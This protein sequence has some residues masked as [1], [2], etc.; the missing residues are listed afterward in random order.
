[1]PIYGD[2]MSLLQSPVDWRLEGTS[3]WV[4]MLTGKDR[5]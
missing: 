2:G 4:N 1:M 3:A 5:R